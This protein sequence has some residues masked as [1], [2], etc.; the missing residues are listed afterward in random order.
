[1]VITVSIP[2]THILH[3]A[4]LSL[5][6]PSSSPQSTIATVGQPL[7]ATLRIS[8]TRRW[9]SPSSLLSAANLTEVGEAIDFV[10]TIDAN[11]EIW[12]VAGQR[13]AH[14]TAKEDEKHEW[15]V[16]LIPLKSGNTLLPNV[17]IR[18]KIKPKEEEKS[19]SSTTE[20]EI[21]NCETDYLSYGES[22]MV[23]PDVRSS[24]VGIGD[25]GV[26]SPRSVMWLESSGQLV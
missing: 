25:M 21:L 15:P 14:F 22:I 2:Q 23:V 26:G 19:K 12:L 3:T 8:H 16:M 11:P 13:R 24:T 6:S 17:D 20:A 4:S 7:V 10:Y 18:A 1:M 9:A 5:N